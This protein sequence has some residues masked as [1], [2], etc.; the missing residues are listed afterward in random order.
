[1]AGTALEESWDNLRT[2]SAIHAVYW[3]RE[4]PRS[5]SHVGF[6]H[7]LAAGGAARRTVCL[8]VEPVALPK[9]MREIR[10][11]KVEYA[12]DE[13]RNART[14]RVVVEAERAESDDVV[15]REREL[16]AG[17]GE[18][19][20]VGLLT[21]SVDDPAELEPACVATETAAA[22]ALC[23]VRRLG[24]QQAVAFLAGAVPLARAA[25]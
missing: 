15:R 17:H 2:D 20:F 12:A 14:G 24:G 5:E 4:W 16:V 6:L 8:V 19:R 22:Q 9:A 13:A 23:E 18:L 10:R 3:I 1:V 7:P 25:S 21:V 11:A